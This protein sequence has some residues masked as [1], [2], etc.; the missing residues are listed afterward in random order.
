[1]NYKIALLLKK[2][3]RNFCEEKIK[4]KPE[5]MELDYFLY[6]TLE[7]LLDI[8]RK[9]YHQY[10]GFYVSGLIPYQA[11]RTMGE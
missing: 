6:D 5:N 8:F 3:Y 4:S 2:H 10:D 7:E 9:I 11:I 1:M